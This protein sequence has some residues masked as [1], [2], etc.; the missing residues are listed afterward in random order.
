MNKEVKKVKIG[1]RIYYDALT[2]EVVLDTGERKGSV[3]STTIEQDI[4][5][6]KALSERNRESFNVIEL[7]YGQ[8]AQDFAECIGYRVNIEK[9]KMLPEDR[10]HEALEFSYPDLNLPPEEQEPVYQSP[11]SEKVE[12]LETKVT[13]QEQA[14]AELTILMATAGI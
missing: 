8:Y 10:K 3:T 14:I 12:S 6:Y 13:L 9:L 2:G 4:Q 5:T 11:L 1:K 7:E